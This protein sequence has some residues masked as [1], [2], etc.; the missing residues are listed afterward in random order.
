MR[1]LIQ[2]II[3]FL[4]LLYID[5]ALSKEAL[6][7]PRALK[8]HNT[9][10]VEKSITCDDKK[11]KLVRVTSGRV[12]VLN[13][14]FKPKEVV[15]GS[16]IFDFKQIKNDLVIMATHALGQTNVVVYLEER[17]CSF[18]LVTVKSGGDDILIVKDPKDSQYEV[19]F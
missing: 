14:P 9:Q 1:F 16:Q 18:N 12:T 6:V 17:R 4:A 3:V 15:L 19:R 2:I 11:P 8:P 13:F 10:D 5:Y 7:K